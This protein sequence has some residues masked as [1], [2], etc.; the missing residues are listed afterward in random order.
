M[1]KPYSV[2]EYKSVTFVLSIVVACLISVAIGVWS[3]NFPLALIA[4]HLF[5]AFMNGFSYL[6]PPATVPTVAMQFEWNIISFFEGISSVT[7]FFV[8]D[9][10]V[11][12]VPDAL[13]NLPPSPFI[14]SML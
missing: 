8:F 12:N 14:F 9:N 11:A 5:P 7:P 6:P 4:C 13:T 1:S 2:E 10:I 3:N